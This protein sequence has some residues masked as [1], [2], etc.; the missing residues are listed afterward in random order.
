MS[1]RLLPFWLRKLLLWLAVL[2]CW[3]AFA[4]VAD[5]KVVVGS[6]NF[7]E[8]YILG[9]LIAQTLEAKGYKVVR[10]FGLGGTLICY[11]A[12]QKGEIDI[13]VEYTG[14]ISQAILQLSEDIAGAPLKAQLAQ[15]NLDILPPLGFNNTYAIALR[16]S[17]AERL[18]IKTIADL[19]Q[20]PGLRVALSHEF[21]KR[22]A[23]G[24]E[25]LKATYGLPFNPVGIEHGLAYQALSEKQIDVTDAY[26]TDGEIARYQLYLAIDNQAF[27][28]TYLAVPMVRLNDAPL[29][30]QALAGLENSLDESV[31]QTMNAMA[32]LDRLSFAEIVSRHRQAEATTEYRSTDWVEVLIEIW[33]LLVRHLQLSGLAV[34]L[35]CLLGIPLAI[36][37]H[38]RSQLTAFVLQFAG[39]LQTIPAI[40]FLALLIPLLGI[41]VL[42]AIVAL[43]F[44]SLLP[45][46]R[47]TILGLTTVDA[48]LI[49][50]SRGLGMTNFQ[51][52]RH[53]TL[54]LSL[55][56]ILAG[57]RTAAVISIGTATLAAFI[58]AGGLGEPVVTGLALN[59]PELILRGAIPA[60]MLAVLTEILFG[61]LEVLLV[62]D[63]LRRT[64]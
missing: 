14:T 13:Y 64:V 25:V 52:I 33:P 2:W 56:S 60:A 19:K 32:V 63:H 8:S 54:P 1:C 43:F 62:P 17:M 58:G 53:V 29:L 36:L 22:P 23:D 48:N 3:P 31:M 21:M 45:I 59:D 6:K 37:V 35:A 50:V 46:L 28:P 51:I 16:K 24:W 20:H 38:T 44:Y 57:L 30:S 34:L 11:E 7:T 39:L 47:N 12:L 49:K 61:R 4:A 15:R 41:G 42:P 55:P 18:Q 26:S 9:E 10:R 5:G 27:F 40:A